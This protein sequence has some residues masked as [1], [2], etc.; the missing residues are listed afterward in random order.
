MNCTPGTPKTKTESP[1]T[2]AHERY[3]A[4]IKTQALIGSPWEDLP[5]THTFFCL[6]ENLA[7]MV[8]DLMSDDVH[9]VR[10]NHAGTLQGEY[11]PHPRRL[12]NVLTDITVT[13]TVTIDGVIQ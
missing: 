12:A 7:A 10:T 2:Q 9:E 11:W 6:P 5:I 4:K 3:D 13:A 8:A 1:V